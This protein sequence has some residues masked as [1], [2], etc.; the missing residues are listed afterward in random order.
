MD[1]KTMMIKELILELESTKA[2]NQQGKLQEELDFQTNEVK[3]L[4]KEL[5]DFDAE[6][7]DLTDKIDSLQKENKDLTQRLE[8]SEENKL[9]KEIKKLRENVR[10]PVVLS[11]QDNSIQQIKAIK[12]GE[13]CIKPLLSSKQGWK[14][15]KT[16]PFIYEMGN[17]GCLFE[18]VNFKGCYERDGSNRTYFF[19]EKGTDNFHREVIKQILGLQDGEGWECRV[20]TKTSS[21]KGRKL[22]ANTLKEILKRNPTYNVVLQRFVSDDTTKYVYTKRDG[23]K[24][25]ILKNGEEEIV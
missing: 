10:K 15:L 2:N 19:H 25:I 11:E 3:R 9:R 23:S 6:I 24:Y 12:E 21:K 13:G 5:V 16:Y 8:N 7:S 1:T 22:R 17:K 4:T 14:T 18:E 20:V